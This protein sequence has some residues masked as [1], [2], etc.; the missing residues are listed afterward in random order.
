MAYHGKF[1]SFGAIFIILIVLEGIFVRKVALTSLK[2]SVIT[3]TSPRMQ[4][5]Y[6]ELPRIIEKEEEEDSNKE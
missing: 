6:N 4:T 3:L 2:F 1:G 5:I